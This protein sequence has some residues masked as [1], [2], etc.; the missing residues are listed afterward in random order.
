MSKDDKSTFEDHFFPRIEEWSI[1]TLACSQED[2]SASR[3]SRA[4]E[5]CDCHLLNLNITSSR[6]VETGWP[7][8]EIRVSAANAMSVARSLERYGFEIVDMQSSSAIQGTADTSR[9]EE[10]LRYLEL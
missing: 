2:Y 4:V 5:D 7:L 1:L 8:V 9:I 6:H 10:L 3:I